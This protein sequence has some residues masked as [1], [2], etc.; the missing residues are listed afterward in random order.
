M[1]MVEIVHPSLDEYMTQIRHLAEVYGN[2][3]ENWYKLTI[4]DIPETAED[5]RDDFRFIRM[6][7]WDQLLE[8][9]FFPE[10][11]TRFRLNRSSECNTVEP[12][13]NPGSTFWSALWALSS[14]RNSLI[15]Y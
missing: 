10:S 11:S 5:D 1:E 3:S 4:R 6:A 9:E 12:G 15:A 2:G 13:E 7:L 14:M 8:R